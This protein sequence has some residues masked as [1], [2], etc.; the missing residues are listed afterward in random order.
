[1]STPSASLISWR[2]KIGYAA[3]D[4]ASCLYWQTFS[5]FLMTNWAAMILR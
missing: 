3:G 5:M 2:E 1:M 4:T